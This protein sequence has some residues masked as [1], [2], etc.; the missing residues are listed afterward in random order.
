MTQPPGE[1]IRPPY[2]PFMQQ[3]VARLSTDPGLLLLLEPEAY[4]AFSCSGCGECCQR[5]WSIL[6]S[7]DYVERW[8]QVFHAHP[9]GLYHDPFVKAADPTPEHYA[10]FHRKSG[11]GECIFLMDDRRC[12]IHAHYG[13]AALSDVCQ[14]FPRY[15]GWFGAFL[16]R[17][18]LNSCPDVNDLTGRFP[19]IRYEVTRLDEAQWRAKLAVPHPLGL[20][21][22]YLWLGLALDLL[23][24]PSLTPIEAMRSLTAGLACLPLPLGDTRPELLD[25]LQQRLERSPPPAPPPDPRPAFEHLLGLL[26]HYAGVHDYVSE[27]YA[28]WRKFPRLVAEERELLA[29]FLRH[30]LAY[31]C[32]RAEYADGKQM[33]FFYGFYFV[34]AQHIALLQWLALYYRER[35]GGGLSREHLLRAATAVSHRY[36]QRLLLIEQTRKLPP[37][38]C[39][40][41]MAHMLVFDWTRE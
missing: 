9:S 37:A 6:I 27:V 15:E 26:S 33:D 12:F 22:G 23:Y 18:M 25:T 5:P 13:E 14:A 40:E 21:Q 36:D 1:L 39:L 24:Q 32:L 31:R 2:Y 8:Q 41:G 10:D 19:G 7:Q 30:Y 20:Y 11:T 29:E 34:L 17:F 16:G 4:Q 38:L 35:E 28:G 3:V